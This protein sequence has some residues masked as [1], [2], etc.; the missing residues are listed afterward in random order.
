M[1]CGELALWQWL[2]QHKSIAVNAVFYTAL[3]QNFV[4]VLDVPPQE[5]LVCGSIGSKTAP[6]ES[7]AVAPGP[8]GYSELR[9]LARFGSSEADFCSVCA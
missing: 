3:V 8:D 9:S 2:L 4:L 5:A 7:A 1:T 6:D